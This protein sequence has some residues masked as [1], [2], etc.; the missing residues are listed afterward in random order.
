MQK[1]VN[2]PQQSSNPIKPNHS[3]HNI[4]NPAGGAQFP[5][6]AFLGEN[7][8]FFSRNTG[9]SLLRLWVFQLTVHLRA[10]LLC[11][12]SLLRANG[13]TFSFP[14][15]LGAAPSAC[16]QYTA[17]TCLVLVQPI[18]YRFRALISSASY[19]WLLSPEFSIYHCHSASSQEQQPQKITA[20]VGS[21]NT[22]R[23]SFRE[24]VFFFF[25]F[26]FHNQKWMHYR[27]LVM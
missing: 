13:L 2:D 16:R 9:I 17:A 20:M 11:F 26:S 19:L 21:G 4:C 22:Q 10:T 23:T 24:V 12:S 18:G 3:N 8:S 6:W 5:S 25:F 14:S 27:C 7:F 15:R 1:L